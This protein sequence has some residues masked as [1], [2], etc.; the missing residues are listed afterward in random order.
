MGKA[1]S[2]AGQ[3]LSVDGI[4]VSGPNTGFTGVTRTPTPATFGSQSGGLSTTTNSGSVSHAGT[5]S[6]GETA[7]SIAALFGQSGKRKQLVWTADGETETFTAI[8]TVSETGNDRGSVVYNVAF[9][10]DGDIVVS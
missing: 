9:V 3:A 7:Q 5:F 1:K 2:G 4:T 8:I 6:V 10:V